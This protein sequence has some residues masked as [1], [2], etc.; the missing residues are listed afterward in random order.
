[1]IGDSGTGTELSISTHI[2]VARN[3]TLIID[4]VR[5][6]RHDILPSP[7]ILYS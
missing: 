5:P 6:R 3:E 1:M 7:I 2:K 4:D